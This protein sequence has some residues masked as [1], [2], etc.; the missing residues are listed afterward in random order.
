MKNGILMNGFRK[1]KAQI[2][3]RME[4]NSMFDYDVL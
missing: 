2:Y 3:L 4:H 1:K